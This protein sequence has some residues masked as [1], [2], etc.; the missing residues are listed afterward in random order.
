MLFS[1]NSKLLEACVLALLVK[2]DSYGYKLTQDVKAMTN[3][4]ESTLYPVLRRL[5]NEGFLQTYNKPIDGRNRKYYSIT[6]SGVEQHS[7]NMQSWKKYK[8]LIDKIFN[9]ENIWIV[10]NL[11]IN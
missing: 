4:S 5:Q 3:I 6:S 11:W 1:I 9:G 7:L 2:E 10:K 8:I